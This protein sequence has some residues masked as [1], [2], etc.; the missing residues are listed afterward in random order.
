M[1]PHFVTI[2]G[3]KKEH[4]TPDKGTDLLASTPASKQEKQEGRQ[5]RLKKTSNFWEQKR[6]RE[7][8]G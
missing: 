6:Y 4:T 1:T 7:L 8:W 5:V 2:Q 3:K